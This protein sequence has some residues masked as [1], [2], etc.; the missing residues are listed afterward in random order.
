P[1]L[2][3]VYT[4]NPANPTGGTN[5]NSIADMNYALNTFGVCGPTTIN[6]ANGT[7]NE[8][9]Y[10]DNVPG[11]SAAN[12]LTI[13]GGDSSQ[14]ILSQSSQFATLTLNGS[15]NV[16][17]KNLT[18]EQTGTSG[19]AVI[20]SNGSQYDTLSSCVTRVDVNSTS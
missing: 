1:A 11:L 17:V 20:F 3:G 8:A 18:L 9:I 10:L 14:T 6:V 19:D 2:N 15:P 13:D 7:Y 16:H 5:F 12:H 4:V